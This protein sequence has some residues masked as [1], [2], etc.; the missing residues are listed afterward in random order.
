ME[1]ITKYSSAT[2]AASVGVIRPPSIPPRTIT[3]VTMVGS[4]ITIDFQ[5]TRDGGGGTFRSSRLHVAKNIQRQ[6]QTTNSSAGRIAAAK[7][8]PMDTPAVTPR[9]MAGT[10]G[11][12]TGVTSDDA[13]VRPATNRRG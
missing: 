4:A 6:R 2:P 5:V 8:P 7:S 9:M 13:T 11:G 10:L 3:G 1:I 12:M